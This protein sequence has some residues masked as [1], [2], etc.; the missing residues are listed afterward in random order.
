MSDKMNINTLK[1]T[2]NFHIS[3][4]SIYMT[5]ITMNNSQQ[6]EVTDKEWS[7]S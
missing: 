4:Q 1:F 6:C 5:Q 3:K 2:D 7:G